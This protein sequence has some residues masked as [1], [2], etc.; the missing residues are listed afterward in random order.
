MASNNQEKSKKRTFQGE[1]KNEKDTNSDMAGL[2][3]KERSRTKRLLHK[4]ASLEREQVQKTGD[5]SVPLLFDQNSDLM[6]SSMNN[7][8]STSLSTQQNRVALDPETQLTW[9]SYLKTQQ[10]QFQASNWLKQCGSKE[11]NYF[12]FLSTLS[13]FASPLPPTVNPVL[14]KEPTTI[15]MEDNPNAICIHDIWVPI[16]S[17]QERDPN[18]WFTCSICT[19]PVCSMEAETEKS[20]ANPCQ[21]SLQHTRC[22]QETRKNVH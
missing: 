1:R 7:N 15:S 9:L 6:V 14:Q 8:N 22:V 17:L 13:A 4:M 11:F 10:D 12:Q 18:L 16:E 5:K 3:H 2:T 20:K 19:K 21:V